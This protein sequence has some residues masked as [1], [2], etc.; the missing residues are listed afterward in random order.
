MMVTAGMA[1][2]AVVAFGPVGCDRGGRGASDEGAQTSTVGA[3]SDTA[4]QVSDSERAAIESLVKGNR[5]APDNAEAAL[6]SG[7][8]PITASATPNPAANVPAGHPAVSEAQPKLRYEAPDN[9]R[10][11]RPKNTMMR[12]AEFAIPK[13]E[14]GSSDGELIVFYFGAG[15][16]GSVTAN[17][18]RWRGMFTDSD[19]NPLGQENS[20]VESFEANSLKVTVLDVAGRYAPSPMPMMPKVEPQDSY[21][22]FAAVVETPE[23]PWFFKAVGPAD[24]MNA[25]RDGFFELLRSARFEDA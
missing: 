2:L 10:Y 23:G 22:M 19:G 16:G 13:V 4:V 8:P 9:W 17:L 3:E 11:R 12:K 15:Q 18:D 24:T 21:R 25:N 1:G 14:D 20:V 6:P 5:P 7:H